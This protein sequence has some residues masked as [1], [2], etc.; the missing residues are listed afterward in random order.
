VLKKLATDGELSSIYRELLKLAGTSS[1]AHPSVVGEALENQLRAGSLS[2]AA[3]LASRPDKDAPNSLASCSYPLSDILDELPF[4]TLSS[5][6]LGVTNPEPIIL[7]VSRLLLFVSEAPN[8]SSIRSYPPFFFFY[9]FSLLFSTA[10]HERRLLKRS[11]SKGD[12]V[13]SFSF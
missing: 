2:P 6:I 1:Y 5:L 11:R 4:S 8:Q 10:A 9:F 3:I 12:A 13:R 7:S